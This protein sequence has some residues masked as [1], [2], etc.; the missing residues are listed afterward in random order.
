MHFA[1]DGDTCNSGGYCMHWSVYS[2][3]V[4]VQRA[5]ILNAR[6]FVHPR[7]W[8]GPAHGALV[9]GLEGRGFDCTDL[10]IG[11][12]GKHHQREL[13]R[14]VARTQAR[15]EVVTTY[16]RMDGTRFDHRIGDPAPAPEAA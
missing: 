13:V 3:V 7:C 16:E 12:L 9:A 2:G 5:T 10:H 6:I 15:D 1:G 14:E 11:P 8:N 4:L